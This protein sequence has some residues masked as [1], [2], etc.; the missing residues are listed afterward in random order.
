[1]NYKIFIE[2]NEITNDEIKLKLS[3]YLG[4]GISV[5]WKNI[6]VIRIG[7]LNNLQYKA[8]Y[9]TYNKLLIYSIYIN[10]EKISHILRENILN[11]ILND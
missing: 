9:F 8:E 6:I 3:P 2:D 7:K 11:N 1:M 10:K 4:L 5:N